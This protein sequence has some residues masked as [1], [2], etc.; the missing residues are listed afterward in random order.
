MLV[1]VNTIEELIEVIKADK[2]I[3][4]EKAFLQRRYPVRFILFNDFSLFKEAIL[5]LCQNNISI[6]K[7][8]NELPFED[9]WITRPDMKS[10][11]DNCL[12]DNDSDVVI[13]PFSEIIR[14]YDDADF[15]S[16]FKE[17]SMIEA[18]FTNLDKVLSLYHFAS[19]IQICTTGI[20]HG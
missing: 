20:L 4:G 16:F 12:R 9:G 1:K 2:G 6:K 11:I 14:F 8:E 3:S 15:I 19:P 10:I 7:I 17:V 5:K 18:N 13:S